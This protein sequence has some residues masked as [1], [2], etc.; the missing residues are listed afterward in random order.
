MVKSLS[1]AEKWARAQEGEA[2]FF[3]SGDSAPSFARFKHL[4][5]DSYPPPR[6]A[7]ENILGHFPQSLNRVF[8]NFFLNHDQILQSLKHWH[9]LKV[10][11]HSAFY[12]HVSGLDLDLT[13][14][15]EPSVSS[16]LVGRQKR[17]K[18]NSCHF[19]RIKLDWPKDWC[20]AVKS[21][22]AQLCW[23]A[24]N[25]VGMIRAIVANEKWEW[26]D[27]F[28]LQHL[29]LKRLTHPSPTCLKVHFHPLPSSC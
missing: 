20:V 26:Q 19:D 6:L 16:D 25:L 11:R 22:K 29:H 23:M 13:S 2:A 12:C 17:G 5:R 10:H 24:T 7:G 27:L 18:S 28:L 21:E 1:A 15:I 8:R 9:W 3:A 14:H 4:S